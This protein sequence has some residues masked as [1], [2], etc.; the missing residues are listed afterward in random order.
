[1]Y[2]LLIENA[3][4][5]DGTGKPSFYGNVA[6]QDG[7]IAAVGR[8]NG[9]AATRKINADGLALA[10]GFID[11]HTHYD[12]QV[13]WDPLVTCS[14]WHGVTTVVTG[15]CGVGVAPCRPHAREVLMGDLVNVEA[16]PLEV[17]RTGID[18]TWESFPEWMRAVA[19]ARLGINV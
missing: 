16:I 2:D 12:A 4:I 19:R 15:N 18:W 3:R 5:C 13:A 10:P 1:M 17:M 14:S 6:V 7:L 11:P 8:G 9:E